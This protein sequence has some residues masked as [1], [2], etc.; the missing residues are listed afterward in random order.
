MPRNK[1]KVSVVIPTYN[2]AHTL[3]KSLNSV[4]NQTYQNFEIIIVDDGSSDNTED[5][6]RNFQKKD[7]RIIYVKHEKNKGQSAAE[8]TGIKIAKG[9]YIAFQDS[10][11][12]WL[13]KKLEKQIKLIEKS[14]SDL[15]VVYTGLLRIMGNK[16]IYVPG[17]W[18]KQKDGYIYNELLK[19]NF[20]STPTIL[21]R[22]ECFQKLGMFDE[23]LKALQDWD[24]VLRF[25]KF[26]KFGFIDE[27]L[28][29]APFMTDSLSVNYKTMLASY[30]L[31]ISKYYDDF[32]KD[33]FIAS[34]HNLS[35]SSLHFKC[36]NFKM[37]IRY[38]MKAFKEDLKYME[39]HLCKAFLYK[40]AIKFQ[41]D[42]QNDSS[43]NSIFL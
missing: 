3:S 24:L 9:D 34:I 37:G 13:P 32:Y 14:P 31:I 27:P 36:R 11:D 5:V 22:K 12:E 7:K 40:L 16:R 39:Y 30:E 4:L 21:A 42:L 43:Y 26:Y 35:L 19:G 8:N 28:V 20:V 2:R 10:D 41:R 23:R 38:L 29:L 1:P 6:I 15:G 18:V 33:K 25:S 17:S